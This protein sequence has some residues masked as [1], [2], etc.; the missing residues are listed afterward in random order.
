MPLPA[1]TPIAY[2]WIVGGL[3]IGFPIAWALLRFGWQGFGIQGIPWSASRKLTGPS[4]KIVGGIVV[5]IGL[6]VG[7][8]SVAK[9]L[10]GVSLFYEGQKQEREAQQRRQENKSARQQYVQDLR[11]QKAEEFTRQWPRLSQTVSTPEEFEAKVIAEQ[12]QDSDIRLDEFQADVATHE[13]AISYASV[14]RTVAEKLSARGLLSLAE[15]HFKKGYEQLQ[16]LVEESPE[17]LDLKRQF[18]NYCW[19][20]SD[21]VDSIDVCDVGIQQLRSILELEGEPE[22]HS[23]LGALLNNQGRRH[24][25]AGKLTEAKAMFE[26]A[27]EHQ[28]MALDGNWNVNRSRQFLDNH[29]SNLFR[30]LIGLKSPAEAASVVRNRRDLMQQNNGSRL[31]E[32]AEQFHSILGIEQ[33]P[34]ELEIIIQ[35]ALA[36]LQQAFAAGYT[37]DD[38]AA[39]IES[40][41]ELHSEV[42]LRALLKHAT[43]KAEAD[44]KKGAELEEGPEK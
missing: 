10:G 37:A 9:I 17:D 28:K 31:I 25:A 36:I 20:Y 41:R 38:E 30:C 12:E 26:E 35:D 29:Y 5:A 13:Q 39:F 42:Q 7:A 32:I 40:F 4:G 1:V 22:D 16:R 33:N 21:A 18:T 27:V 11:Q 24:M 43:E 19:G 15:P 44:G 23:D 3:V 2:A 6:A 14:E 34:A 8:E